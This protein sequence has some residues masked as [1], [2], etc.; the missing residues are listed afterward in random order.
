VFQSGVLPDRVIR[1]PKA[2]AAF[3]F[4]TLDPGLTADGA[5]E[6]LR[7]LGAAVDDIERPRGGL[8][9]AS[10]AIGLGPSF[11][12]SDSG[13]R[14][15]LAAEQTPLGLRE[16]IDLPV[17][18]LRADVVVYAMAL[19][20]AAVASFLQSL[21]EL[22]SVG[23]VAAQVERGFQRDDGRELFGN[24]DGL[25]NV[26]WHERFRVVFV[27]RNEFPEEPAWA[28]DGSYLVYLKIRQNFDAWTSLSD[29]ARE[30]AIG[31]RLADGSR[32]DL[33]PRSE[34]RREG[35]FTA[36]PP[37]ADS[38]VRKVGP[39]GAHDDVAIFRRGVPYFDLDP[40]GGP[41]GGLHFASFQCSL[42][43]FDVIFNEWMR[44]AHFPRQNAGVDRLISQG[45]ISFELG[46]V[47]FVPAHDADFIGAAAF[48]PPRPDPRPR[49]QGRVLVRKRAVDAAG[50]PV[51]ADL[52]GVVFQIIHPDGTPVGSTFV[53]NS[54]GHAT[55]EYL[56][57]NEDYLLREVT[58]PP[59]L[60]ALGDVP[61]RLER[62]QQV[63]EV[64][65][66]LRPESPYGN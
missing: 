46:G 32:L 33:P 7:R 47:F 28:E 35:D 31:R 40:N 15:G 48:E 25:R 38:H 56:P 6:F 2:E 23:L 10:A 44:G 22:R 27:D 43:N 49:T 51:R 58:V 60:E 20:E 21:A 1:D 57:I 3:V 66:R 4:L 24:R 17:E 18:P 30:Q 54:A 9:R 26:P 64:K 11:F 19:E 53:T 45:L 29:D 5:A 62:R 52:D 55:S 8:R 50:N 36:E 13:V 37:M 34:P 59:H 63:V 42:R 61:F 16:R 14:F 39:R 12:A 41:N 65:D